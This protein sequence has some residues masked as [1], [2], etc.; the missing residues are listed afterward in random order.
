MLPV[1]RIGLVHP[2]WGSLS[3]KD[4]PTKTTA[5][6]G[7]SEQ[8]GGF[9]LKKAKKGS[10]CFLPLQKGCPTLFISGQYKG[11]KQQTQVAVG[12]FLTL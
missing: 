1:S 10:Q 6:R 8:V 3:F 12:E 4:M 2:V 11:K 7:W 9:S 5:R